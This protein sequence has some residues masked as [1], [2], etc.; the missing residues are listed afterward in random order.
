MRVCVRSEA[1]PNQENDGWARDGMAIRY[2]LSRLSETS[3][4]LD[5]AKKYYELSFTY[6]FERANDTV[7]FAFC[8]PYTYSKLQNHIRN[9]LK[10]PKQCVREE[11]LCFSLSGLPVPVLT[12][13][14]QVYKVGESGAP[15][16][17]DRSEFPEDCERP[18][19]R[20]KKYIIVC[21]RVHPGETSA[22]FIMHGFLDFITGASPEAVALRRTHVFRIVPMT[23]PDGVIVGNYRTSFSGNDLNRQFLEPNKKLHPVVHN[24]K[25]LFKD[26]IA[27][28]LEPDPIATFVDIHGHSRKKSVFMYGPAYPLHCPKYF[29]ARVLPKLLDEKSEIFRYYSCKFRVEK[30]KLKAARVVLNKEFGVTACYTLEA[31]MFGYI[32]ND[33]S[34]Q[35]LSAEMLNS[36]GQ[37][38][39]MCFS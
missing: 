28:A 14:S 7:Y 17:I 19:H 9:I 1:Q 34:T 32:A 33:R 16:E 20:F 38:L 18:V 2:K 10:S 37:D 22:S 11:R 30:S 8:M 35:E 3:E 24:I 31:S 6:N 21:A 4:G 36:H 29:K 5:R 13:T 26:I 27:K 12:V 23:N 15:V 25:R 39:G